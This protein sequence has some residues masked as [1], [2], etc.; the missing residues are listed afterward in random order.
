MLDDEK[1]TQPLGGVQLLS[2]TLGELDSDAQKTLEAKIEADPALKDELAEIR[3]HMRLHQAVR[4]VA[5]RRGSFERLRHRMKKEGAFQ[6]AIPGA[7]A[8]LRRSFMLAFAVGIIAVLLLIAIGTSSGPAA[9]P[10]VIGQIVFTNPALTV[11]GESRGE[12]ERNYLSLWKE[13]DDPTDTGAYDAY[14]WLPTGVENTYSTVELSSNSVFKFTE[15]RR[16]VL[17][18]GFIRRLE[19]QPGGMSEGPFVVVT[20]HCT[21]EIEKGALSISITRDDVMTQI[22]VGEGNARV[23][24]NDSNRS[25]PVPAGYCTS[26]ERGKLPNPARPVLKLTLDSVASSNTVI[27]VTLVNDGYVPVK[28]RRAVD[29][30]SMF[31]KPVYLLHVSH[32][33]EH[34]ADEGAAENVTL[35][36]MPVT[37]DPDLSQDH[38]GDMWLDAGEYYRFNF[39]ISPLLIHTPPVEHWL[40]LE[41]RGDLYGPPGQARVRIESKNLKLDLRKR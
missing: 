26:V 21:V 30:E 33:A 17:T 4:K 36:P 34:S 14:I 2:Y 11:G 7:H 22:S 24:G 20:P 10:D 18:R 35:E 40:R 8:M 23:Y 19:I 38:T 3:E 12:V 29:A 25:F 28:I 9:T 41:Y 39:D 16:L 37:P 27:Q 32:V 13:G 6:G 1:L 15:T 31:P 5:P